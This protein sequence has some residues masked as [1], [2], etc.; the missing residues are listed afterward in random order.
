MLIRDN[1]LFTLNSGVIN[2]KTELSEQDCKSSSGEYE[3]I[4]KMIIH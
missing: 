4:K 2:Q 3:K 1:N